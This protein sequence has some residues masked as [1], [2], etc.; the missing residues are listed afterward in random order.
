MLFIRFIRFFFTFQYQPDDPVIKRIEKQLI[1]FSYEEG[2]IKNGL[3]TFVFSPNGLTHVT[4]TELASVC[5]HVRIDSSNSMR[6][7]QISNEEKIPSFYI[8]F[9]N[10]C[11][12]KHFF[13]F[14]ISLQ[15]EMSLSSWSHTVAVKSTGIESVEVMLQKIKNFFFIHL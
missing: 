6:R 9:N 1:S 3:L 14:D 2:L 13:F 8:F 15:V 5:V 4:H 10:C 12:Y 11:F 7:I